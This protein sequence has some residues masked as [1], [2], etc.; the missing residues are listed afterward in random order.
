MSNVFSENDL[1]I[2]IATQNRINFDFLLLMFPFEHFSNFNLVIVNQTKD[3]F[4]K[5]DYHNIKVIN[6]NE[7]GLSKSR[8]KAIQNA[9]KKFA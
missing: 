1:E 6:V 2:L 7:K 9:S 4:L 3:W 8:N 5:S